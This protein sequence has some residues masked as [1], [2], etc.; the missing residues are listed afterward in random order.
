M[1]SISTILEEISKEVET[2]R[3]LET[4]ERAPWLDGLDLGMEY[5]D[6]RVSEIC[7]AANEIRESQKSKA[8]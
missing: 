3:L 5:I 6:E 2:L 4:D 8:H 1:R 7:I